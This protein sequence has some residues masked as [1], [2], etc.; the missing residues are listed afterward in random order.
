MLYIC[1]QMKEKNLHLRISEDLM[2]EIK[3]VADKYE[4][5]V[6]SFTRFVL[7]AFIEKNK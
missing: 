6:S 7:K 2:N 4:M 5:S 1:T 3:E